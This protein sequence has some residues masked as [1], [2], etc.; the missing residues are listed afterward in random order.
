MTDRIR[1]LQAHIHDLNRAGVRRTTYFP[2]VAESLEAT[3]GEPAPIRRAKA[4]A[5]LLDSVEPVVLPHELIAGSILGMWPLATG[6]PTY[7][8]RLAEARG[9]VAGYL[10]RKRRGEF[11]PGRTGQSRWALMERDHYDANVT[12]D[13][14]KR[15]IRALEEEHAGADDLTPM[16]IGRELERH[17]NFDYGQECREL[18]RELPWGVANHLDLNYQRVARLGLSAIRKRIRGHLARAASDDR[19][20]FYQACLLAVEAAVG[21]VRRYARRLDELSG[22]Q[23]LGG[24]RQ[25]ELCDMAATC[26][27]VADSPPGTFR[28]ALQLVWLVHVAANINGGNAMSF[29]RLDQ[30][31][32]PF[33]RRDLAEG[34]LTPEEAHTL[35]AC[36][37]LKVNEPHMRTVQSVCLGGTTPGGHD[38]ANELTQLCLR[39]CR[40][41]REPYPNT[42]ARVSALSPDWY[43][44]EIVATIKAGFGQP[45]VL[46]DDT[47]IPNLARL[48]YSL[49]DARDYYNMGCVEIM[50]M[51]KVGKWQGCG[52][53]LFPELLQELLG[54][55]AARPE[56]FP[57]FEALLEEY[58]TELDRRVDGICTNPAVG[59]KFAA[60]ESAC[61]PFGS[62]LLDDCLEKGLDMFQGGCRYPN[63]RPV[64]GVGIGTAV[65]S[66]A[67]IRK[68]VFNEGRLSLAELA[69]ILRQ[70][71]AG[72]E[73]LRLLLARG[74]SCFGN[75]DAETDDIA[76]RIFDTFGRAVDR[77]NRNGNGP[78]VTVFFSYTGH[79]S[80]G[81][82]VGA[83]PNG[84]RAADTI[85]NGIGPTQGR[86]TCGPT[87]LINSVCRLDHGKVN[88]AFALNLK[89]MSSVLDSP[90]GTEALTNLIRTYLRKGGPQVQVN[91]LDQEA[92]QDAL[93]HPEQHADLVVRVGGYCEHFVKLDRRLQE[94]IVRRSALGLGPRVRSESGE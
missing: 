77:H 27:R 70:D 94:E 16:E 34:L 30:Y 3:L 22:D 72:H 35:L 5:H 1:H 42:A 83:T 10:A 2:L 73:D 21:F 19:R 82:A 56:A 46:N 29:A 6:L 59:G 47:W 36:A 65:D 11:G 92:L 90:E 74:T 28:E 4:F 24:A 60:P 80:R 61:D 33:Y 13:D 15:L 93:G 78:F 7:D 63:I 49:E 51:G 48:G 45:M 8:E 91:V 41:L 31:L 55:H 26:R 64:S 12:Y 88:G 58:L 53:V 87:A 39:V 62:A 71:F 23:E 89:F 84:R 69:S 50:I 79:V 52:G 66:L 54:T 9:V 75:D 14:L 38:G 68:F 37:W 43:V 67:A 40:D 85:S 44:D 86:D 32:L 81:Q 57:S 17:L 76:A 25:A 18:M 20:V